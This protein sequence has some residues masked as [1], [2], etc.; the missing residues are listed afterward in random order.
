MEAWRAAAGSGR[1]G[2]ARLAAVPPRSVEVLA[3]P[4]KPYLEGR[5]RRASASP[6]PGVASRPPLS[7]V[8]PALAAVTEP[9]LGGC[10]P[11][12]E[13]LGGGGSHRHRERRATLATVGIST[14][15]GRELASI[16]ADLPRPPCWEETTRHAA[17]ERLQRRKQQ[18]RRRRRCLPRATAAPGGWGRRAARKERAEPQRYGGP[19]GPPAFACR[20]AWGVAGLW[21]RRAQHFGLLAAAELRDRRSP[22]LGTPAPAE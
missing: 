4:E 5:A 18:Q 3:A 15:R 11:G 12:T 14:R 21:W 16:T 19:A 10:L 17:A 9:G 8:P 6:G 20:A 1:G 22:P 2:R 13:G 7:L